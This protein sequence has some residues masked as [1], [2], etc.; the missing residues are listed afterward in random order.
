MLH[1][2]SIAVVLQLSNLSGVPDSIV[3]RAQ[4]EVVRVYAAAGVT[5]QWAS[6]ESPVP[7]PDDVRSIRVVLVPLEAGDVRR[8]GDT[9]VMGVAARTP[10]GNGTAYVYYRRVEEQAVRHHAPLER[11]LACVMAHELGHLLGTHGHSPTGVMRGNWRNTEF[12]QASEG[13]LQ[14][15]SKD[16]AIMRTR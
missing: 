4:A 3:S 16:A 5:V 9:V 6:T 15:S 11:V 2:V 14:F 1:A 7:S 12:R 10:R 8:T 13:A